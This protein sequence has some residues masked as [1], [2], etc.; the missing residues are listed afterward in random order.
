[1]HAVY[2]PVPTFTNGSS[3]CMYDT[4]HLTERSR[5]VDAQHGGFLTNVDH[6]DVE[7]Y[8]IFLRMMVA[9]DPFSLVRL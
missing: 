9:Y 4:M 1:M 7:T 5:F 3:F 8:E 6:D 2:T